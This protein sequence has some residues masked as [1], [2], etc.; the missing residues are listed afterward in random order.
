MQLTAISYPMKG[1]KGVALGVPEE[2]GVPLRKGVVPL[3]EGVALKVP[4]G[5]EGS[6]EEGGGT[7]GSWRPSW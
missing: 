7:E 5:T 6:P 1:M 2:E 3:R 4:G